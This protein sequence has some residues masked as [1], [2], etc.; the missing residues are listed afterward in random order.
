MG[1]PILFKM[2]LREAKLQ[3]NLNPQLKNIKQ[4]LYFI[5]YIYDK[6]FDIPS[7]SQK[8]FIKYKTI[9]KTQAS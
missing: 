5:I 9:I 8:F 1:V 2:S 7:F 6:I 3:N 4:K